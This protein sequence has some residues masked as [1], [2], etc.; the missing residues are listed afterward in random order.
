MNNHYSGNMISWNPMDY[1]PAE[2][3]VI[4]AMR[5]FT[6][7]DNMCTPTAEL[8][9]A[10]GGTFVCQWNR[11]DIRE[12]F[13]K[14]IDSYTLIYD[15]RLGEVPFE[16]RIVKSGGKTIMFK[17]KYDVWFCNC[18]RIHFFPTEDYEWMMG[19][20]EHRSS[21][22][23]C[24]NCGA[25][26]EHSLADCGDEYS[27]NHTGFERQNY[28]NFMESSEYQRRFYMHTGIMVPLKEGGYADA[29]T[30]YSLSHIYMNYKYIQE[31]YHIDDYQ[32]H[33]KDHPELFTVDTPKLIREVTKK[34]QEVADDLLI[35]IS[36]YNSGID[37]SGT[38]YQ[39]IW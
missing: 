31:N 10:Y 22:Q 39:H 6:D 19:D 28:I 26:K 27:I 14:G 20:P 8:A 16:R 5:I 32:Q 38:K 36:G 24:R 29:Y 18:G 17:K 35:S 9:F 23:V 21:V 12:I 33:I 4:V 34:Y 30:T 15:E 3:G 13:L 11:A 2:H 7:W 1:D 37:W 25:I